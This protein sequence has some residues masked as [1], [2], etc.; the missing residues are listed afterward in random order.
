MKNHFPFIF[1]ILFTSISIAKERESFLPY[2]VLT[3]EPNQ[4]LKE[5]ETEFFFY[6]PHLESV[7]FG[8][9]VS[10][11][12]DDRIGTTRIDK[13]GAFSIK[14]TPGKHIMQ[15]YLPDHYEIYIDSIDS[16]AQ[17][18]TSIELYWAY[19]ELEI[20]VDKP[21]IYLYPEKE[22]EVSVRLESTGELNFIYPPF[23]IE[24]EWKVMAS[25]NGDLNQHGDQYRYL[26]WEATQENFIFPGFYFQGFY[27]TPS[28][29]L[30]I[31]EEICDSFG[32][33]SQ[34]KAD[35]ITF[36]GPKVQQMENS[37]IRV[38]LN[39]EADRFGTLNIQPKPD[40]IYRIYLLVVKDP[41]LIEEPIEEEFASPQ[42]FTPIHREG[43]TVVEWGGTVISGSGHEKL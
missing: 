12:V 20:S 17:H 4:E 36:W 14:S 28:T 40:H 25:P 38:L 3:C 35:L 11:S 6:S 19:T 27:C 18:R 29:S 1:L 8:M 13:Q 7:Y 10:Y 26:F 33:N 2:K 42:F 34:E 43:F 15:L 22:M 41:V 30:S 16:K 39:E 31:L 37:F 32:L 24:N 5:N 21:V 23:N 9:E